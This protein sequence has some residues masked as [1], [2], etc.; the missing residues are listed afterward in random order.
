MAYID[1]KSL[2]LQSGN[3]EERKIFIEKLKKISED[4]EL[5]FFDKLS[6]SF[7]DYKKERQDRNNQEEFDNNYF[8]EA[9]DET[10]LEK[11]SSGIEKIKEYPF[12]ENANFSL[13]QAELGWKGLFD[14]LDKRANGYFSDAILN[15]EYGLGSDT[16]TENLK[17]NDE[18][19]TKEEWQKSEFYRPE[20]DN[21]QEHW[22]LEDARQ[23]AGYIDQKKIVENLNE[24][25]GSFFS[26][27]L[28][29]VAHTP[30]FIVSP[31]GVMFGL[32]N[33]ATGGA[34]S[35][36][37]KAV[38]EGL[39]FAGATA[40][41]KP[42][43]YDATGKKFEAKTYAEE[44]GMSFGA[45]LVFSLGHQSLA[46]LIK[47]IR[48][49]KN[50]GKLKEEAEGII[51]TAEIFNNI[52]KEDL[53]IDTKRLEGIENLLE[54]GKIES[55]LKLKTNEYIEDG[56]FH[57]LPLI[58][59]NLNVK[60]NN[61]IRNIN[62]KWVI[63]EGNNLS[64]NG[65]NKI[66]PSHIIYDS[67]FGKFEKNP[68]YTALQPK[69]ITSVV[70]DD[71][72]AKA[73]DLSI[74]AFFDNNTIHSGFPMV[75]K[76]GSI[77]SG[78]HRA[79]Y[80]ILNYK[81]GDIVNLKQ[82][83]LERGFEKVN[84]Y[85]YPVI[86]FEIQ[87]ELSK[88][89]LREL[90]ET[91]NKPTTGTYTNVENA[92][93]ESL[94]LGEDAFAKLENNL[95]AT[96]KNQ[97]FISEFLKNKTP[98]EKRK[99]INS[100][101]S[102]TKEAFQRLEQ[103]VVY[104]A[105]KSPKIIEAIFSST[106]DETFMALQN[107]LLE[108]APIFARIKGLITKEV[109][110]PKADITAIIND[111]FID[112]IN[113]KDREP[114]LRGDYMLKYFDKLI[115]VGYNMQPLQESLI[116]AFFEDENR[117]ASKVISKEKGFKLI[118]R[119]ASFLEEIGV[120]DN[121]FGNLTDEIILD[122]FYKIKKDIKRGVNII[123][124][125]ELFSVKERDNLLKA[126][127]QL[128]KEAFTKKIEELTIETKEKNIETKKD[129]ISNIKEVEKNELEKETEPYLDILDREEFKDNK[130]AKETKNE[131]VKEVEN[132]KNIEKKMNDFI[133]CIVK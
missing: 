7:S 31:E 97:D 55:D 77:I 102:L 28:E 114:H 73:K 24:E 6:F 4:D 80:Q 2:E 131:I 79:L 32:L 96:T 112:L 11:F 50:E 34:S 18:I 69:E 107:A 104:E 56:K 132:I 30:G 42:F 130:F 82:G 15:S 122:E 76:D 48:G 22:T 59:E 44:V 78:N 110:Q 71:F 128:S 43:F 66:Q 121:L 38:K 106:K 123:E 124:N 10:T 14:A 40:T 36:I 62:G 117:F 3:E 1:K 35:I 118:N 19:L 29:M 57:S 37:G 53:G 108:N 68:N 16:L 64:E 111:A 52:E 74:N 115:D 83:F 26:P 120:K 60:K 93:L 9:S 33:S 46:G 5:S 72:L 25:N 116:R 127:E 13:K 90:A 20:I 51:K 87:D 91:A 100:D 92:K 41:T 58:R 70:F 98:E 12:K 65:K 103:V 113:L 86:A 94:E 89:A 61:P 45:G 95:E 75:L 21:F 17:K 109:L 99:L 8:N 84:E 105:Y 133:E 47:K 126:Q 125:K 67:D 119:L 129:E 39:V 81:K 63:L 23:V 27:V 85:D 88:D 49:F 54:T 101:G